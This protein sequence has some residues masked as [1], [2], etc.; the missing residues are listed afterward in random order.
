MPIV[1]RRQA[2]GALR[3]M[4]PAQAAAIRRRLDL[5]A[6]RPG[7]TDLDL[8]RLSG[9]PGLRLRVGDWRVIL[10][11]DGNSI[12]VARIAPRGDVYDR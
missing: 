8:R 9:R 7:R 11:I 2:L 4:Q 6:A 12:D 5:L 1:F 3:R 10:T